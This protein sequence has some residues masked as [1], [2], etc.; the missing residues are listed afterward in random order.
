MLRTIF[1]LSLQGPSRGGWERLRGASRH[2]GDRM[3]LLDD[4]HRVV[5]AAGATEEIALRLGAAGLAHEV[6]LLLG[7]DAFGRGLHAEVFAEACD[8][9]DDRLAFARLVERADKGA[10]DLDLV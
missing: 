1:T 9:A 7:L 2:A 5:G 3:R 10:I 6:E 4:A 8:G